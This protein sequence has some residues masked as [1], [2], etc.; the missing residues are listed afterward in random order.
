[1]T[2]SD[3][4]QSPRRQETD[5][6]RRT[7]ERAAATASRDRN[8]R[9]AKSTEPDKRRNP[10]G[11]CL[12]LEFALQTLLGRRNPWAGAAGAFVTHAQV[13]SALR[14]ASRRM[15]VRGRELC[16]NDER[17][18][19]LLDIDLRRIERGAGDLGR[20]DGAEVAMMASLLS[21]SVHLLGFDW[22]DGK[23][24]RQAVYYQTLEQQAKD[25]R[26][27]YPP[28]TEADVFFVH[29]ERMRL[30]VDLHQAGLRVAQI[31]GVFS[32]SETV[33]KALLVRSGHVKRSTNT[34]AT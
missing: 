27:R 5:R 18:Q 4:R 31:A 21:L 22:M 30:I 19:L 29:S 20:K 33:V 9:S 32:L 26:K 14:S 34:K 11:Y 23:P 24:N 17:L 10:Y 3:H 16:V 13:R 25:D 12:D 8:R 1:M 6:T 15:R 2:N 28:T 7:T